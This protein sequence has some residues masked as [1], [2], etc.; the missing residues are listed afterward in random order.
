MSKKPVVYHQTD[1]RWAKK[2]YAV[3]GKE[4]TTV[5]HSGCGP[6]CAAMLIETITGKKFTPL[7]ACNW[8]MVHGYKAV[9][10][11]TYYSYFGPQF[12][13]FGIEC[14]QYSW[15]KTY[16]TVNATTR[17]I[18]DAIYNYLKRGYY[19]IALMKKGRWTSGGHFIVVYDVDD[20]FVYIN[21]PASTKANRL[22]AER[23]VFE[24]EVAYYWVVDAPKYE[25]EQDMLDEKKIR[26]IVAD[27]MEKAMAH[28]NFEAPDS[29]YREAADES[30]E[31]G[32]I[33]G[34]EMGRI[35]W[36]EPVSK[37]MLMTILKRL[38][39]L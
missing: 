33:K 18:H 2:P 32:I 21:D 11:G 37:Q 15:V 36:R 9:G 1:S 24:N 10:Q 19:A 38:G 7:D 12:K 8:S 4:N 30:V 23:A 27:E 25:E 6:S 16:H 34:D 39:V 3:A 5:A 20:K 17:K 13:A 28:H 29:W 35:A 26:E 22:K 31:K 14:W